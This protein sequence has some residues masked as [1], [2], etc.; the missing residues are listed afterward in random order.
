MAEASAAARYVSEFI[1]TFLL[2][3]TV[4]C[5]VITGQPVWGGVSIACVLTVMIYA[6][7]KSSGAN[8]NPAVSVALGLAG[9][10]PWG[11]VAIYCVVQFLA[12]VFAAFA[13]VGMFGMQHAFN[14]APTPGHTWWQACLVETIYTFM[15]CFVVLNVAASKVH[16]GFNQFYGLAIGFVVVAG[17]Y[18]AG[19]VSM[20]CFNPAVAIGLD[21]ASWWIGFKFGPIYVMFELIGAA[22]AT[23]LFQTCRPEEASDEVLDTDA[24]GKPIA[25]EYPMS[26][27]LVS[28]FLGTYML[29]LTVGLNVL[30]GSTA[31]AFSIAAALMSMIYALGTCSGAHF[32]PAVTVAIIC[33]G[34]CSAGEG[35]QYM[36]VQIIA[37]ISA[38]FTYASVM[39]GETF[40]L[41]SGAYRWDQVLCAEFVFTFILCFV[42]LSVATVKE[43][44]SEYFGFA[45]GMCVTVG[46]FAIGKVS[47]GSLNPAVSFGISSS[48]ILGGGGFWPCLV[49]TAI[50]ILAGVVASF[51]FGITQ[52]SEYIMKD[53]ETTPL[54]A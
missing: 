16:G 34:A 8:F 9:K 26:S 19:S 22:L 43:P 37:G 25:P 17:A 12:G 32:N 40:Q 52:P 6:L 21:T 1:G 4:G 5:N 38:A 27:K 49:Y 51:A 15:L 14:L 41:N 47:G 13:Y 29:V 36:L 28:E 53:D 35:V 44:L 30:G 20:G 48:H 45:I 23:A 3:F 18:G 42:V 2:V 46:G 50:E 11:E 33:R 10:M 54:T 39:N 24:K 31:G 7:G